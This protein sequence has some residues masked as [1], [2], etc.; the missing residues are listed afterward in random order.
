MGSMK[1]WRRRLAVLLLALAALLACVPPAGQA[2]L[3]D[4]YLT[5]VNNQV[6][7]MD[8]ATMPFRSGGV[9]YVSSR[10]FEGT[11]LGVSY[12]RSDLMG[13]AML[14]TTKIDL[15]FDLE[16]QQVYDKQGNIY[17]G[18]AIEKGGVMFFP[19]A[20]V[21]RYFDLRW[22]ISE[23]E[24]VPLI[25]IRS[26]EDSLDDRSFLDAAA[27]QMRERYLE[28]EKSVTSPA[29]EPG[30]PDVTPPPPENPPP[31]QAA[32]GQKVYLLVDVRS[33]EEARAVLEKLGSAQ[34]TFLLSAEQM[35]EGDLV[36]SLVAGGHAVALRAAGTAEDEVEEEILLARELLWQSACCWLDLVFCEGRSDTG[37]L[38]EDTGRICPW[39]WTAGARRAWRS[40]W[41]GWRRPAT[42]CA[43]GG[44]RPDAPE[45]FEKRRPT[46]DSRIRRALSGSGIFSPPAVFPL[47][48]QRLIYR[49]FK[50]KSPYRV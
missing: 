4:V 20:L 50:K 8:S 21:C 31:V 49:M 47:F 15:R 25:R 39:D 37:K 19:V 13:L 12:V 42:G 45:P 24:T 28:Y 32:E 18:S 40:F 33:A 5:A 1:R 6:L 3:T 35:G 23:T 36:R 10:V 7:E 34:A 43:P 48:K 44:L 41:R 14:Y 16:A 26:G 9:W 30:R 46:R 38:L 17:N 29:E 2:Y 22:S 27:L 11:D